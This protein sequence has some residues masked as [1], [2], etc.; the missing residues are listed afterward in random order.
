MHPVAPSGQRLAEFSDRLIARLID[1]AITAAVAVA[2]LVPLAFGVVYAVRDEF[3]GTADGAVNDPSASLILIL[4]VGQAALLLLS[5]GIAYVYEV[6]LTK[7]TGQTVGKRVMK[8]RVTPLHPGAQVS[9]KVMTKRFLVANVAAAFVPMLNLLD[10][11]W[12]LWDQ[13]YRQCLHDKYAETVVVKD[14]AA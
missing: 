9:R 6:E 5:I 13:P 10:G 4:L 7:R 2:L 12:Q 3:S 14:A 8:I 1:A 11:L